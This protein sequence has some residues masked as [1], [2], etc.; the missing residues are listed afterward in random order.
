MWTG[1]EVAQC[2][3]YFPS[4][5]VVSIT[6]SEVGVISQHVLYYTFVY[7]YYTNVYIT[8]SIAQ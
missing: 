7:V 2:D 8:L 1:S 5:L 6:T 4:T 3:P